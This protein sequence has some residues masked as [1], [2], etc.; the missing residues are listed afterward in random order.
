MVGPSEHRHPEEADGRGIGTACLKVITFRR[1][2][3]DTE[4]HWGLAFKASVPW[5][6]AG[7]NKAG[8]LSVG[9]LT[10][11]LETA[12]SFLLALLTRS[13]CRVNPLMMPF[14]F[15]PRP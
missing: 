6:S 7:N 10:R 2:L 9:C 15:A 5:I 11:H 12:K 13:G 8:G 1:F 4:Q 3:A 14:S